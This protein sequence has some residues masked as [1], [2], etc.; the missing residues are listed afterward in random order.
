[1][2]LWKDL[3]RIWG[4]KRIFSILAELS[5]NN[6][7]CVRNTLVWFDRMLCH[8]E[9]KLVNFSSLVFSYT[10]RNVNCKEGVCLNKKLNPIQSIMYW[11]N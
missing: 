9:T 10:R 7:V 8:K 11:L 6:C 3:M 4:L 1:M 2:R 5:V